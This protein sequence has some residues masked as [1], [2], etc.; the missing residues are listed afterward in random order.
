MLNKLIFLLES[1]WCYTNKY[2]YL[3]QVISQV[4][5]HLFNTKKI[6]KQVLIWKIFCLAK[7]TTTNAHPNVKG[8]ELPSCPSSW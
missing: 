8:R 7:D 2:F 1:V 4:A 5:D 6:S 3:P